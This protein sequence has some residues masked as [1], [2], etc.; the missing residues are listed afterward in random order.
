[1]NIL[2]AK[3]GNPKIF[4][5]FCLFRQIIPYQIENGN[6]SK[7]SSADLFGQIVIWNL[8]GK[9][10]LFI[11]LFNIFYLILFIENK[12]MKNNIDQIKLFA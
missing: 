4:I 1:V 5:F 7:I 11:I 9:V 10:S 6:L 8:T 12:K 2:S 3:S